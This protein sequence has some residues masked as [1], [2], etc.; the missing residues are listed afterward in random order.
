MVLDRLVHEGLGEGGLVNL[1]VAVLA[2][3]DD[4]DHDVRVELLAPLGREVEDTAD[5]LHVVRVHFSGVEVGWRWV[6]VVGGGGLML[7]T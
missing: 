5:R 7:K 6:E 3:A 1:V 2:V 4:V